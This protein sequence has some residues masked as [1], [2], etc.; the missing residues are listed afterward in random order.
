M[1]YGNNKP[2]HET[3]AAKFNFNVVKRLFSRLHDLIGRMHARE[4]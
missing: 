1:S 4:M 2:F 3:D